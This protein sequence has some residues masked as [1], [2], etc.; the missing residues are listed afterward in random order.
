MLRN[1]YNNANAIYY[2][3]NTKIIKVIM[4]IFYW[5]VN[6]FILVFKSMF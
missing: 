1:L 6:W 2:Y 5:I 3:E 4:F